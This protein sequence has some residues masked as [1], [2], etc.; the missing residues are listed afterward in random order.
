VAWLQ[1]NILKAESSVEELSNQATEVSPGSEGLIFLPYMM[2][3]RSP[4][5]HTNARG[6]FFG[7][8]LTTCHDV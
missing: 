8:S 5:W 2:G 6:V 3:E 1:Q 4:I 7:L